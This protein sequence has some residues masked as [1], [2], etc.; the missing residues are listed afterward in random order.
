MQCIK[1]ETE[2][3]VTRFVVLNKKKTIVFFC[4]L[5]YTSNTYLNKEK[6]FR[7]LTGP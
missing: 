7:Y 2:Y 6:V 3:P 5:K 4:N 1:L